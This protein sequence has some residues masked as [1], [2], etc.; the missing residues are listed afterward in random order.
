MPTHKT[1]QQLEPV[2]L[3]SGSDHYSA[4]VCDRDY[5]L[6]TVQNV[7]TVRFGFHVSAGQPALTVVRAVR[8]ALS[9]RSVRSCTTMQPVMQS[10]TATVGQ[11]TIVACSTMGLTPTVEG[12][13]PTPGGA[14]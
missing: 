3:G 12:V 6:V 10:P 9:Y 2:K 7:C 1:C 8:P 11:S 14:R 13:T 4:W 5:P